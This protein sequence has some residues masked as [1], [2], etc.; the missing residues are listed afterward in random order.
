MSV[1]SDTILA[2]VPPAV[3]IGWVIADAATG[4]VAADRAIETPRPLAQ[5]IREIDTASD[6]VIETDATKQTITITCSRYGD[7]AASSAPGRPQSL[8]QNN[9]LQLCRAGLKFTTSLPKI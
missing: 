9:L 2:L 7:V 3:A 1:R 4:F 6:P 8:A 5:V